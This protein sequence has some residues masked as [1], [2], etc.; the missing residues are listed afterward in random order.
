MGL[1]SLR[2][3]EEPYELEIVEGIS[4][5]LKPMDLRSYNIALASARHRLQELE[6]SIVHCADA[7][8]LDVNDFPNF[9]DAIV[10]EGVFKE[11]LTVEIAKSHIISWQGVMDENDNPADLTDEA[12]EVVVRNFAVAST[13]FDKVMAWHR[14]YLQAK[15]DS[16]IVAS[17]ISSQAAVPNTVTDAD[18]MDPPAPKDCVEKTGIIARILNNVR[19]VKKK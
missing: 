3:P 17:G 5:T 14:E 16:G 2:V 15:K 9:E 13:F 1:P 8:L 12:V 10:R 18:A 19:A 6:D 4:F 7:N 11:Y